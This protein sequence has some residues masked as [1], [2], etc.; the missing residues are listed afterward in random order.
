MA[1]AV[2]S[3]AQLPVSILTVHACGGPEMLRYAQ[4][5]NQEYRQLNLHA[6]TVLTSWMPLN[7]VHQWGVLQY[8]IGRSRYRCRTAG[9]GVFRQELTL[10]RQHFGAQP[11]LITPGI[12]TG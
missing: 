8:W 11:R 3:I 4:Q 9:L 2:Q 5:A 10:I 7:C 6:V 1:K 12:R